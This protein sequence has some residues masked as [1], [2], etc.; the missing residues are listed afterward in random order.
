MSKQGFLC[1]VAMVRLSRQACSLRQLYEEGLMC[2]AQ[3]P[4]VELCTVV[5]RMVAL[6]MSRGGGEMIIRMI[7]MSW[8]SCCPV[9]LG[10]AL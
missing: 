4:I 6:R 7:A 2:C 3:R 5:L 10:T 9:Y 8:D 1:T